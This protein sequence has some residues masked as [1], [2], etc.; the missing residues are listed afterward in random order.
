MCTYLGKQRKLVKG[1]ANRKLA[2]KRFHKLLAIDEEQPTGLDLTVKRICRKFLNWSKRHHA[3]DTYRNHNF[4]VGGF[5][6]RYGRL[7]VG[8]LTKNHVTRWVD[9]HVW[10]ATSQY[11]ARRSVFRSFNWA[12]E[13]DLLA[14]NPLKGMKRPKPAPRQRALS[15]EEYQALLKASRGCFKLF[16]FSLWNT[17]ARPKELRTLLWQHVQA[18][19]LVLPEH[20]TAWQTCEPR[21]IRL[22]SPMRK[23][24][25]VLR[26]RA[27]SDHVFLNT[28]GQPWTCNAVRQKISRLK[29]KLGLAGDVCSYL[30]RHAFGTN[31]ILRGVDIATT[32]HLMGHRSMD[33]ISKVYCHLADQNTHLNAAMDKATRP[34]TTSSAST[35][36]ENWSGPPRA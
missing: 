31:A 28:R 10:N 2:E 14:E 20:K 34:S 32:A 19:R 1:K 30:V 16:L 13:E 3:A 8:N 7:P 29:K 35:P 26:Q 21:V 4:Y 23:L 6:K 36:L 15:H 17:G 25:A 24:M 22:N 27:T 5:M 18:D 33:M 9:S 11:N 12:V